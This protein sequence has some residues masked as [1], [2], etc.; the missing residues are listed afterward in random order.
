MTH[1]RRDK[2][3]ATTDDGST[4]SSDDEVDDVYGAV[5]A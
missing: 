5:M 3:N 4:H 2:P 1:F